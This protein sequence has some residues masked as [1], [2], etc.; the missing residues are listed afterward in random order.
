MLEFLRDES[1]A[2]AGEYVLVLTLVCTTL[3]AAAGMFGE[4]LAGAL[5]NAGAAIGDA[6]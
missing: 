4:A 3:A 1:G 2:T 5:G 6:S